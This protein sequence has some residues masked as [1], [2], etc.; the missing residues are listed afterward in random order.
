M[1]GDSFPPAR[2]SLAMSILVMGWV[3]GAAIVFLLGGPLVSAVLGGAV[4]HVR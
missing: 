2:V 4:S 3:I 1:L